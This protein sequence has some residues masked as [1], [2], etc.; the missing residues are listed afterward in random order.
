LALVV[1]ASASVLANFTHTHSNTHTHTHTHTHTNTHTE[2]IKQL[3]LQDL[4]GLQGH[5]GVRAWASLCRAMLVARLPHATFGGRWDGVI[6]GMCLAL[7]RRARTLFLG[8][9]GGGGGVL[10]AVPM[11]TA[12][13]GHCF[14]S[15][16]IN[17]ICKV[18]TPEEMVLSLKVGT[19]ITQDEGVGVKCARSWKACS[20]VGVV[21]GW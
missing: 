12:T 9:G 20:V 8:G 10:P 11:A 2:H 13:C 4:R 18:S 19:S 17:L 7:L 21:E 3:A 14:K 16:H 6:E 5:K 1:R 15:N